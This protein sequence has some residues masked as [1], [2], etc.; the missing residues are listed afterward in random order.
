MKKILIFIFVFNGLSLLGQTKLVLDFD[1][2]GKAT[3]FNEKS[4]NTDKIEMSPAFI[5]KEIAFVTSNTDAQKDDVIDQKYFDLAFGIVDSLGFLNDL[6]YFTSDINSPL[7]EGPMVYSKEEG[8]L[9]FTRI[10]VSESKRKKRDTAMMQIFAATVDEVFPLSI[11]DKKFNY[12]HPAINRNNDIMA[13]SSNNEQDNKGKY[14][15]YSVQKIAD[16]FSE[17]SNLGDS[18]NTIANEI[19]PVYYGNDVI[20]FSSDREGGYGGLDIYYTTK[21]E[22][23]WAV[24][25]LLPK[26]INSPFDDYS[27]ILDEKNKAYFS[28]NR[29]GGKGLDDIYNISFPKSIFKEEKI[30]T[31]REILLSVIEKLSFESMEG[32]EV[33]VLKILPNQGNFNLSDYDIDLLPSDK[34]GDLLMKLS[35]K[36][37]EVNKYLSDING[38]ITIELEKGSNYILSFSKPDYESQELFFDDKSESELTI[39]MEPKDAKV[40]EVPK[41]EIFIPTTKGA[42]VVFDNIYYA[43]NSAKILDGAAKEL[44]ALANAMLDNPDMK[45]LL[46]AHTD[47]RG[48]AGYNLSLSEQRANA[49]KE[50]LVQKGIYTTRISTI[51]HGESRIRNN[52]KDGVNCSEEE[53]K[54]NRR[55]EVTIVN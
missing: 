32:V 20:F 41:P 43:Y 31:N 13:F 15:I 22:G 9:Y 35:P 12:C 28:S 26:P 3:I 21:V 52:C 11:N 10:V 29:P 7:H 34:K 54:F 47:A 48:K 5:D 45:V 27:F 49:A 44:D 2:I 19:Y 40:T 4:I 38:S 1:V 14:D 23:I 30:V 17:I 25:V 51:G 36:T 16:N 46:A 37:K 39:A 33:S 8:I 6:S 55:T 18:I 53:H 42:T 24:P 50:Y